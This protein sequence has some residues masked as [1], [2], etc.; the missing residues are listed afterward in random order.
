MNPRVNKTLM[1][2]KTM[3]QVDVPQGRKESTSRL[4]PKFSPTSI[5]YPLGLRSKC[6]WRN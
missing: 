3:A 4:L 2:F 5:S 6:H 1:N